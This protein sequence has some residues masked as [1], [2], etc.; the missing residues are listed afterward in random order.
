MFMNPRHLFPLAVL[1]C[2]VGLLASAG[3]V[4]EV[5]LDR[6]SPWRMH[7][8]LRPPVIGTAGN[9]EPIRMPQ[10]W[11]NLATAPPP[12]DWT[13]PDYDDGDWYRGPADRSCR[14]SSLA[15][16]R[17]RGYFTVADPAATPAPRLT[18]AYHG[19][20]VVYLNGREI[21]RAHLPAGP[22]GDDALAEAYPPEAFVTQT[23]EP[24]AW[25]PYDMARRRPSDP[26]SPDAIE[27]MK[28]RRRQIAD[29]ALPAG[30]LRRG[31]NVLAIELV[32]APYD[33][34]LPDGEG[35]FPYE[36]VWDTCTLLD[37][38]LTADDAAGG[39][40]EGLHV[41]NSDPWIRSDDRDV[42]NPAE[43]L[44]PVR[45]AGA[46]NGA[47]NGK[48]VAGSA[49]ALRGLHATA[50]DLHGDGGRIA[51]EAVQIRYALPWGSR[52]TRDNT[53]HR[54]QIPAPTA[55][56]LLSALADRPPEVVEPA[57]GR[58]VAPVW[59]TV[60][61]PAD[62]A[63]GRYEGE[64]TVEAAG[65]TA[66]RVPV[67]LTVADWTLP[68]PQDYRTWVEMIQSPAT[69]EAE[70]E[71]PRWSEAHWALI[72]QSLEL[73]RGVGSRVIYVPLIR[74]TNL[75]NAES[76]VRWIDGEGPPAFDFSVMDRY[77]DLA[78][79]RC[80]TPKIVVF[81]VWDVFLV[82]REGGRQS[83]GTGGHRR[84]VDYIDANDGVRGLRPTVTT[85][86][87]AGRTVGERDLPA[88]TDPA[89]AAA[90]RALFAELRARM[91]RRGLEEAMM[92]G[93]VTDAR[94]TPE[95]VAFFHDVSGG[96]PWVSH[97][98]GGFAPDQKLHGLAPI[99]YQAC[100]WHTKF[101]D[102]VHTHGK[103]WAE[104]LAGWNQAQL[105]VAFERNTALDT[106]PLTRWRQFAAT[107][108]TGGQRGVG[109][110]GADF[111][112]VII[113][114][115]GRRRGRIYQRYP[116]S[117]WMN[118]NITSALL[119]PG[120]DG[121]VAT[122]RLEAVREGVQECEARIRI[123]QALLD[124][125]SRRRLGDDLAGRCEQ[126]LRRRWV[127][128]YKSLSN[129]QMCGPGWSNALGWRWSPGVAGHTWYISSGWRDRAGELFDLAGEVSRRLAP[130][131]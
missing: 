14:T 42:A 130:K 125:G 51:A 38:S 13:R 32:R 5:L 44:R 30:A 95:E 127:I 26:P 116:Q 60:H 111:W 39:R 50:T 88:Y 34:V 109:R 80:G 25:R 74:Q 27:R 56:R 28:R 64:L 129:L 55:G 59:I 76:M 99:G 10:P 93:M 67:E 45:I 102:G 69:L 82:P 8:E 115:R 2:A 21:A 120:P 103:T 18:V 66:V 23:G 113:D 100:V 92:L 101:T 57:D 126:V 61:V 114:S 78:E 123:E 46:R 1:C 97:G 19:G 62:A 9:V 124:P 24:L 94:P 7:H 118:L 41:W 43:P 12:G 52:Q 110:L 77:L 72:G 90:W 84:M 20:A 105:T 3:A 108:I 54:K 73:L 6:T 65:E 85:V 131:R 70:Y 98:H 112:P 33:P 4:G 22:L 119:A 17:L 83:G 63:A 91:R 58:A 107:N 15:R 16:L 40:A 122:D 121:P 37:V 47:F 117:L 53:Y 96:L 71:V 89:G 128:L 68:D 79:R 31:R 81:Y 106:Y 49:R 11:M 86:D 87:A 48:V 35:S 29:L 75:G 104:P 36:L